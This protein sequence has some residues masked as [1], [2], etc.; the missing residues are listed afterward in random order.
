MTIRILITGSRTW[1]G[2]DGSAER[3][4]L[5]TGGLREALQELCPTRPAKLPVLVHGGARGADLL[6]ADLWES[7]G[8]PTE[9]HRAKWPECGDDCPPDVSC[10]KVRKNRSYCTRAGFRRNAVMVALGADRCVAFI[11]NGSP[12]ATQCADLAEHAGIPTTR[13]TDPG[14]K[15]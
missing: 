15:P 2:G 11:H 8:L 5:L 3:Q 9:M 13:I 14:D 1:E 12:G 10:R 6:A 7:W 4:A